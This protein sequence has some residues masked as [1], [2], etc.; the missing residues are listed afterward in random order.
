MRERSRS[1]VPGCW[2]VLI[3]RPARATVG[4]SAVS[5]V[6]DNSPADQT[7]DCVPEISEK[8]PKL[9]KCSLLQELIES[10]GMHPARRLFRQMQ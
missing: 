3:N 4:S 8:A 2:G 1:G 7:A 10:D 9:C 6:G 5:A